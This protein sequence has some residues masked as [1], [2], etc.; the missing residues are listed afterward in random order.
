MCAN[1]RKTTAESAAALQYH[2]EECIED[3]GDVERPHEQPR[4]PDEQ[5]R[6]PCAGRT[7]RTCVSAHLVIGDVWDG[8]GHA[9]TRAL[10]MPVR[11]SGDL[12]L[13]L[14]LEC[15]ERLHARRKLGLFG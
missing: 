11:L 5:Q 7:R 1:S 12:V 14:L 13:E 10:L 8:I 9:A 2:A 3:H 15:V 6:H 4:A